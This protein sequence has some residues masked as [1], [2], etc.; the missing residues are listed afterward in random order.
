[1]MTKY[2]SCE[3]CEYQEWCE[4]FD[5]FFGCNKGKTKPIN[6]HPLLNEREDSEILLGKTIEN[7]LNCSDN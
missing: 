6:S 4:V 2:V 7:M 5:P 3:D 1:M